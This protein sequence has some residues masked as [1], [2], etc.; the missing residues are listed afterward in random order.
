M[1]H[2]RMTCH[3]GADRLAGVWFKVD[4]L[5]PPVYVCYAHTKALTAS[6]TARIQAAE[7]V[8]LRVPV[9]QQGSKQWPPPILDWPKLCAL[10]PPAPALSA[11][12]PSCGVGV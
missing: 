1:G 11:C 4:S 10:W 5:P 2:G 8:G 6:S 12:R 3:A 7:W 9:L